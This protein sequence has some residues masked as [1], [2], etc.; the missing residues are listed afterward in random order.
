MHYDK[1]ALSNLFYCIESLEILSPESI[2]EIPIVEEMVIFLWNKCYKNFENLFY[3][4]KIL[5]RISPR[6]S[7]ILE[8]F[9]VLWLDV[10]WKSILKVD[11]REN[12]K[13]LFFFISSVKSLKPDNVVEIFESIRE[14]LSALP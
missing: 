7:P 14:K 12:S 4:L 9:K 13:D 10:F 8:S 5:S 6:R 3:I 2:K 1:G 11:L